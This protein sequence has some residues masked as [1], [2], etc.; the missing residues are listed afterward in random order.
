MF[1]EDTR[2]KVTNKNLNN[3]LSLKKTTIFCQYK[4]L[5]DIVS[6]DNP[7]YHLRFIVT[8]VIVSINFSKRLYISLQTDELNP[9]I[10]ISN[11]YT[12]AINSE[13][14]IWDLFGIFFNNNKHIRRVLTD[15]GFKSHPLRKSFPLS[16][17]EET[18]FNISKSSIVYPK[19]KL[20]QEYRSNF[21]GFSILNMTSFQLEDLEDLQVLP[22][23]LKPEDILLG[24]S[25]AL[26]GYSIYKF[27][28]R[29]PILRA[30]LIRQYEKLLSSNNYSSDFIYKL[31]C[32]FSY[33]NKI[34]IRRYIAGN[35]YS[36]RTW[37]VF[38]KERLGYHTGLYNMDIE[39][40]FPAFLIE[41]YQ[42][43]FHYKRQHKEL[44]QWMESISKLTP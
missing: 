35:L 2:L 5:I 30:I 7:Q 44:A 41:M 10:S 13:R 26:C 15:Y 22:P 6:S 4:Q 8:Y 27:W 17:F 18:F 43:Q 1:G 16:G 12:S 33:S 11:L 29:P 34:D 20:I 36:C 40:S 14:E 21:L 28:K 39:I 31:D 23:V 37:D 9:I 3:I 32:K 38:Y 42:I 24:V 19:I 25:F